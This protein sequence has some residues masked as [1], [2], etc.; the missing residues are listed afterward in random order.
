MLKRSL[1]VHIPVLTFDLVLLVVTFIFEFY[2][3]LFVGFSVCGDQRS[4]KQL[5]AAFILSFFGKS[6]FCIITFY[7]II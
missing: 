6:F 2:R 1:N 5:L 7:L 4:M 3:G